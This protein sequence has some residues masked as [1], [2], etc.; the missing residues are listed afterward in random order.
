MSDEERGPVEPADPG[1]RLLG[2]VAESNNAPAPK[3]ALRPLPGL[4]GISLYLLFL[5]V[6][7][8]VGVVGGHYPAV[9]LLL[10]VFLFAACGGVL[11]LFRWAWGLSLAAGLLLGGKHRGA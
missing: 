2:D 4:A 7:I 8:V 10:P 3:R 9:F 5:A 6:V 11:M 1:E